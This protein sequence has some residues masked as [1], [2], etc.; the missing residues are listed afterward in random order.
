MCLWQA[1]ASPHP[2]SRFHLLHFELFLS[3]Q[4]HAS[5][6]ATSSSS[7]SNSSLSTLSK[8][9]MSCDHLRDTSC[10]QRSLCSSSELLSLFCFLFFL[11]FSSL[12]RFLTQDSQER[13]DTAPTE[14]P[15]GSPGW[16][17]P[18]SNGRFEAQ[19]GW[20]VSVCGGSVPGDEFRENKDRSV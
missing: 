12:Y 14:R 5:V 2:A 19:S 6:V 15:V 7:V 11:S 13:S 18:W 3:F 20:F 10:H 9:G 1:S 4:L 16:P 17:P 8:T